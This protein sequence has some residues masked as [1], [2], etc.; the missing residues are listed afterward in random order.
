MSSGSSNTYSVKI[1]F[2]LEPGERCYE[3]HR[4]FLADLVDVLH[5]ILLW[6]N[7]QLR[8]LMPAEIQIAIFLSLK[9]RYKCSGFGKTLGAGICALPFLIIEG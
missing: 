8:S 6:V 9:V 4:A 7:I 1:I 2:L 5:S 3:L